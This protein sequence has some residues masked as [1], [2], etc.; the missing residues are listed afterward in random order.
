MSREIRRVHKDWQHPKN[1]RGNYD[2]LFDNFSKRLAEWDEANIK[3]SEGLREDFRGG[4]KA[5]EQDEIDDSFEEWDGERPVKENYMPE[6]PEEE[7][8]HI[9]MYETCSEGS[10]ISPAFDNP[11]DLARWLTDNDASA[12]GSMTATYE[13]WLATCKQGWAAGLIIG[14]DGMKSGVEL[15]K[16]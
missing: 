5:K 4:W 16:E 7:L 1:N 3:W 15:A 13:E 12:F 9:M 11:E 6:W 2:P 10:P 8:T 14:P